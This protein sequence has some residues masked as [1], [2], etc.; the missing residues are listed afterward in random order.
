VPA[1]QVLDLIGL[2]LREVV[3]VPEFDI[4]EDLGPNDAPRP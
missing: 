3:Q 2:H 1:R 4:V